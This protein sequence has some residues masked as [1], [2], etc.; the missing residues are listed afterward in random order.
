[1]NNDYV[2]GDC[3]KGGFFVTAIDDTILMKPLSF[4]P[5][6]KDKYH[7]MSAGL[8]NKSFIR[9]SLKMTDNTD[10]K[11]NAST[12]EKVFLSVF[13]SLKNGDCKNIRDERLVIAGSIK[14]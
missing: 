3:N 13:Y 2:L 9:G 11:I 4:L 8:Q 5:T 7:V 14:Y 1:M 10:S 6:N 12:Q